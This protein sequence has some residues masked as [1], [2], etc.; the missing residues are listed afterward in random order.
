MEPS[1]QR[2]SPVELEPLISPATTARPLALVSML[3]EV[4]EFQSVGELPRI[5]VDPE[6]GVRRKT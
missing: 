3:F 5:W 1:D 6:K 2:K 4:I